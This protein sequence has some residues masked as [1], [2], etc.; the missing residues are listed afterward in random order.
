MCTWHSSRGRETPGQSG[1]AGCVPCT[2][3]GTAKGAG[4]KWF[5]GRRGRWGG[6]KRAVEAEASERLGTPPAYQSAPLNQAALTTVRPRPG[7]NHCLA[8]CCSARCSLSTTPPHR[9]FTES[10][11]AALWLRQLGGQHHVPTA[12]QQ[13]AG[14]APPLGQGGG[15]RRPAAFSNCNKEFSH[16]VSLEP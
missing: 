10:I 1:T 11:A 15:Q 5:Q 7:R 13:R 8:Q 16:H 4:P 3:W 6:G 12:G 9:L 14:L 2:R